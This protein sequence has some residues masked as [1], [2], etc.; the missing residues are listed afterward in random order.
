MGF[1]P[2]RENENPF[3]KQNKVATPARV[4]SFNSVGGKQ[5][6]QIN[7]DFMRDTGMGKQVSQRDPELEVYVDN[8]YNLS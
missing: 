6:P 7:K 3:F 4:T 1:E 5:Q 8:P 2:I